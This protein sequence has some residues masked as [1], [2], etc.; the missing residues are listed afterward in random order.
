MRGGHC[1][2]ATVRE[3]WLTEL[4]LAQKTQASGSVNRENYRNA[5]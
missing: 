2:E 4:A 1:R 5:Q 3:Q